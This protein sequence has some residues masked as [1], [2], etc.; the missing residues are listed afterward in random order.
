MARRPMDKKTLFIAQLL[1]TF[2]MALSMSGIMSAFAMGLTREWLHAWPIQ[3]LIA[4]PIS[5]V[6]TQGPTRVAFPLTFRLR[7]FP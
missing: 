4:W 3:F 2:M 1:I 6:L 7:R 5:F